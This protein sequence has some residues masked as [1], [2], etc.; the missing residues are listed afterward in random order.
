MLGELTIE[1]IESI[2]S[3][4]MI[5]RIGCHADE[6]IMV[7]PMAY[8]YDNG[9]IYGHSKEGMKI[10]IMR[11]NPRVCFEIDVLK[12]MQNWQSV[13]VWGDY[14]EL[15]SEEDKKSATDLFV[16]HI[17]NTKASE[18]IPTERLPDPHPDNAGLK[19]I[20][21]RIKIT[22]KTGRFEEGLLA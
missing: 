6:K 16:N 8:V 12:D 19:A 18:S 5:G 17:M 7:V 11:S 13:I 9:F 10:N 15:V 20:V 14:E 22:E 21:F 4:Q 3:T 1:Q 2:L